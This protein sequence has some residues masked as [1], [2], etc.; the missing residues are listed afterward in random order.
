[1]SFKPILAKE[2]NQRAFLNS[3]K[4][5]VA[6]VGQEPKKDFEKTTQ[7]W[8]NKPTFNIKVTSFSDYIE[9]FVGVE[10]NYAQR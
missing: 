10:S 8:D 5:N 6:R 4:T 9:L 7:T 3:I 2:P 1:M